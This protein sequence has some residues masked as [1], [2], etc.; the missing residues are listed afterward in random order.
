LGASSTNFQSWKL[1]C[2]NLSHVFAAFQRL[3]FLEYPIVKKT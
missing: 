3:Y 2:T 1:C